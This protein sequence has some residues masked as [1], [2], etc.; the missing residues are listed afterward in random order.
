MTVVRSRFYAHWLCSLVALSALAYG[1]VA[2][3]PFQF[4]AVLTFVTGTVAFVLMPRAAETKTLWLLFIIASTLAAAA[5]T[6][7]LDMSTFLTFGAAFESF[8]SIR[9]KTI[10]VSPGATDT[11]ILRLLAPIAIFFL[12]RAVSTDDDRA[13]G[14][15]RLLG[16]WGG[17][18]VVGALIQFFVDPDHIVLA[19]KLHY[20]ESLTGP[21]VNRNN[22]AAYIGL[23][24]QILL[25][26]MLYGRRA[27]PKGKPISR[28]MTPA[29]FAIAV[30]AL[31][32]T[33]S[34]AGIAAA[35]LGCLLMAALLR[36]YSSGGPTR[37][38]QRT[39]IPSLLMGGIIISCIGL[40]GQGTIIRLTTENLADSRMCTYD[41]VLSGIVADANFWV[42]TGFG[43]FRSAF[44]PYRS[45]DCGINGIWDRA[46][47][48]FLEG[49]FG[50]GAIF[51]IALM[52][53]TWILCRAYLGGMNLR[54]R[55]RP[56]AALGLSA[57]IA[58]LVHSL[59]DFPLQIPGVNNLFAAVAGIAYGISCQDKRNIREHEFFGNGTFKQLI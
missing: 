47:N 52:C 7:S 15:L 19:D 25:A 28:W 50:L 12:F 56:F 45:A 44:P 23:I 38:K 35:I 16:A 8:E 54:R 10:S 51:L 18:I 36:A 55:F 22:A 2:E 29:L 5:Y 33:K 14:L 41:S 40:F 30:F 27:A 39:A 17:A 32:L 11:A 49:T 13:L 24:L 6:Q 57:T 31:L 9:Q 58:L 34:R 20:K 53:G 48:S 26:L 43:A 21:F 46:H 42:G 37:Q 3:L 1:G 59:V 4:F